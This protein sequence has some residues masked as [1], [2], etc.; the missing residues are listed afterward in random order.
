MYT[1]AFKYIILRKVHRL[2]QIVQAI[3]CE[4]INK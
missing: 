2:H 3:H 1:Y 4:R